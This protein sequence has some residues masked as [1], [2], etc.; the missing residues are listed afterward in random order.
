MDKIKRDMEMEHGEALQ[1][2][3]KHAYM[4]K[5]YGLRFGCE[6]YLW[7]NTKLTN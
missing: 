6:R 4:A 2:M 7:K 1:I 3:K 5:I